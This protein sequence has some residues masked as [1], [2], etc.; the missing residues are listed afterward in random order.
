MILM[1]DSQIFT[2]QQT[3]FLSASDIVVNVLA[4]DSID[5]WAT[6]HLFDP[7]CC[8]ITTHSWHYI[9]ADQQNSIRI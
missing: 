6:P 1:N 8:E 7:V 4:S 3:F 9:F 2:N 5:F